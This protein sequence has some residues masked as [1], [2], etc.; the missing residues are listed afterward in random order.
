MLTDD[1]EAHA[2]ELGLLRVKVPQLEQ[3]IDRLTMT[4][5]DL[6]YSKELN[7]DIEAEQA[8]VKGLES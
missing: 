1:L 6:V 2:Y 7:R 3:E 8:F 4:L 5:E